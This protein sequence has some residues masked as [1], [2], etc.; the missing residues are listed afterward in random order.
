MPRTTD[1]T[2]PTLQRVHPALAPLA[3]A[4]LLAGCG[5]QEA[6]SAGGT[7]TTPPAQADHAHDHSAPHGG[8]IQVLGA[9]EGHLEIMHDHDGGNIGFYVYGPTIGKPIPVA[10]P[11]LTVQ[12]KT[13][14]IDVPLTPVDA[15]PDGTA[16]H[17]KAQTDAL[18]CDPWEGRVRLMLGGKTFQAPLEGEGHAHK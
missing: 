5:A 7:G 14:P 10:R 2:S 9:E 3:L 4:L 16:P 6:P 13:G 18:K 11:V 17:W 1:P 8:E 15:L 12:A